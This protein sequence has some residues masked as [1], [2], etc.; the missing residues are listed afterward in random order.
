MTR[1]A[2]IDCGTNSIRLLVADVGADGTLTDVTRRME[3]VRLGQGVDQTG[4]LAPEAIERTRVALADY[5]AQIRALGASRVRMCATSASRDAANATDFTDMVL[6]TLGVAPEVVTGDAEAHLS[7]T[8]AVRGLVAPAPFLIVDIGGGSTEFVT[9][10]SA[11]GPS[12]AISVDIGCVRMT[13]RHLHSTPPTASEVAAAET[14]IAA[15]V[16]RALEAVPGREAATLVG[17]AGSVTTVVGIALDLPGYDPTR[18]HHARISYDDVAKVTADLLSKTPA[19]RLEN[20]IMHPGRADVIGAGALVLRI[21]MERAGM[22]SVVAS[23]HDIL[24]GIA[25]SL[26]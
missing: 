17:V 1:V 25:Y 22:S 3:I 26:A 9:G 10:S 6:T 24:D 18:I 19:E 14:D 16:D 7:Y 20:P 23:E 13:E 8:G 21:I 15:A 4:R 12:A 2:A 5:T 11:A